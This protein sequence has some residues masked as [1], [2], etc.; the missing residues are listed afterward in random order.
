MARCKYTVGTDVIVVGT[1][2]DQTGAL[3]TPSAYSLDH[4]D[5][6]GNVATIAQGSIDVVS[7]GVLHAAVPADEAGVWRYAWNVTIGGD[8]EVLEGLFCVSESV[9]N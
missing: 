6:S 4:R 1:F 8:D 3:A 7:T 9:V 5:P 2:K